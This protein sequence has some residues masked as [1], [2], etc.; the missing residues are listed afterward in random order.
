MKTKYIFPVI[1]FIIIC[2][3]FITACSSTRPASIDQLTDSAAIRDRVNTAN[4][5]FV[6]QYVN[7]VG[8]R[9]R[10][11]NS[12]Q[13]DIEVRKDTVVSYLPYFGRGYTAPISPS[14]VDFDFTS[15]H[16]SYS[17]TP[18]K[19]GWYISIKPKDKMYLQELYFRI[20]ENGTATL[21]IIS[22]DRSSIAY[23]G[24]VAARRI[25]VPK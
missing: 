5:I 4:F 21:N 16:F 11:L 13:Y 10:Q 9:R 6:P 15:T 7:G 19:Q 1:V 25:K 24:Y 17:V 22:N 20:F 8:F 18:A 3:A 2:S 23:D 14:D 12:S